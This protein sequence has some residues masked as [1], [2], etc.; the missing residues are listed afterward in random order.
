MN[1]IKIKS[2]ESYWARIYMAGDLTLARQICREY[3][4]AIG[5]C[6]NFTETEYLYKYGQESGFVVELMHYPR[7]PSDAATIYAKAEE[8]GM[9]LME[10]LC[11]RSFSILAPD[12]TNWYFRE[13]C[14]G[15]LSRL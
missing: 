5:L 9:K 4:T 12:K 7:F 3:C 6:V 8:L 13:G 14:Y 2:V 11:Q 10:R 15:S 1:D